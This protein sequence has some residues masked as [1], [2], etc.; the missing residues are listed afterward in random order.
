M[1]TQ[2]QIDKLAADSAQL[3]SIRQEIEGEGFEDMGDLHLTIR[4]AIKALREE[5][6]HNFQGWQIECK[7]V[8][9]LRVESVQWRNNF[10]NAVE[11][12]YNREMK[13]RQIAENLYSCL[14]SF[15]SLH[16]GQMTPEDYAAIADYEAVRVDM[17]IK[18]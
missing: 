9:A 4:G 18:P 14:E 10:S 11:D 6:K 17:T 5:V 15:A 1:I 8:D 13:W 3:D 16:P 2:E 7:T 12:A